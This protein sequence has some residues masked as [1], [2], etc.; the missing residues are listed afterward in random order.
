MKFLHYAG[1]YGDTVCIYTKYK[2]L[3]DGHIYKQGK[4]TTYFRKD[5]L[6]NDKLYNYVKK[7]YLLNNNNDV[8]IT[9]GDEIINKYL[10]IHL[11]TIKKID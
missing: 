8:L 3:I 2:E 5:E 6:Y 11:E 4:F 1:I 9:F 10:N 7:I